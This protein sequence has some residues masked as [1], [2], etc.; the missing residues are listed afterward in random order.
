[1]MLALPFVHQSAFANDIASGNPAAVVFPP[2][3]LD[4]QITDV[5]RALVSANFNQ[6]MVAW[7]VPHAGD[8]QENNVDFAKEL[9]A[10]ARAFRIRY[11]TKMI[12]V[13]LCGH[14]TLCAATALFGDTARVPSDVTELHFF[15]ESQ[16][17]V[18]RRGTEDHAEI[19]L[20]AGRL[21][22]FAPEDTRAEKLHAAVRKAVGDGV[23]IVYAG[24]GLDHMRFYALVELDV[25]DLGTLRVDASAFV[26]LLLP[27]CFR[28]R[29]LTGILH[30]RMTRRSKS[31]S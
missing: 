4:A 7:V 19:A 6:P 21:A 31:M 30:A 24:V 15:A 16:K 18:A 5:T 29:S 10:H 27:V 2:A 23:G 20:P 17:I 9:P 13:P 25:A 28:T 22:D 12:E 8:A 11:F 14:A 3:E 26:R 1:M